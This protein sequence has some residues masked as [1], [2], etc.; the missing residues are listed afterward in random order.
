MEKIV[1]GKSSGGANSGFSLQLEQLERRLLLADTAGGFEVDGDAYEIRLGGPGFIETATLDNLIVSGTSSSSS[2]Y[3]LV[4]DG[5]GDGSVNVGNL[6]TSG[7]DLG[8]LR[9]DG[10]LGALAV[11]NL[12]KVEVDTLGSVDTASRVYNI[13]GDVTRM[14]VPGG[15]SEATVNISG[16]VGILQVG[17]FR[18]GT[19]RIRQSTFNIGGEVRRLLLRQSLTAGSAFNVGGAVTLMDV[20]GSI[21]SST[22]EVG[23]N[24]Q[25]IIVDGGIGAGSSVEVAGDVS[26]LRVKKNVSSSSII[27]DGHLKCAYIKNDLVDSTLRGASIDKII[28]GDDLNDSSVNVE[29]NLVR[30]QVADVKG[31]NLRVGG[32]LQSVYVRRDVERAQISSFRGIGIIKVG[33]DIN[34]ST[35]MSGLDIGADMLFGTADDAEWGDVRI[36]RVIIGGDMIDSSLAAGMNPQ[37]AYFGDGNDTS[38][39]GDL[40]T[41]RIERVLVRGGITSS[42][43]AGET[44][45]IIASD[46]IGGVRSYGLPFTGNEDV[47]LQV[48]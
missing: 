6:S 39:N 15:I 47:L 30:L 33:Q 5:D 23:G 26:L 3:V 4:T 45:A 46:G 31:L 35:V 37:G 36:E 25:R 29:G 22:V 12:G 38:N 16:G 11:G 44:F 32:E 34:R 18:D 13:V 17:R 42:G 41:A 21:T 40:G 1:A 14:S 20:D 8:R 2:L 27:V 28:I 7:G 19:S 24:A 43:I 48:F 9:I 10:D